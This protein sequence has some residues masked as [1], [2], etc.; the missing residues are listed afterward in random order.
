MSRDRVAP[1]PVARPET[2]V[3]LYFTKSGLLRLG[4]LTLDIEPYKALSE[5]PLT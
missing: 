2:V 3:G 5:Y 4:L 1:L